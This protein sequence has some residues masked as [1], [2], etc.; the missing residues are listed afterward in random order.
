MGMSGIKIRAVQFDDELLK[1]STEFACALYPIHSNF[2]GD[3]SKRHFL[4]AWVIFDNNTILGRVVAYE[5]PKLHISQNSSVPS[6]TLLLGNYECVDHP[7]SAALLLNTAMEFAKSNGYD[8][9]IGP[10][11]G[12]TWDNYR[13][14]TAITRPFMGETVN[15]DYYPEQWK[16]QG[17]SVLAHYHSS[18]DNQLDTQLTSILNREKALIESGVT[19]RPIDV[20]SF[21]KELKAMHQF[22]HIAF[23]QNAFF[24]PISEEEF[25][26]KYLAIQSI[27]DPYWV[28]IVEDP[29]KNL[30]GYI[31]AYEDRIDPKNETVIL[32]TV[33]RSNHRDYRGLGLILARRLNEK[34]IQRGKKQVIHAY[35]HQE[36]ASSHCSDTMNG[37]LF[38]EYQLFELPLT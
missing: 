9:I 28:E 33:A 4:T 21:E 1:R 31:L 24:T 17:F 8:K 14:K 16:S 26:N 5:N 25:V 23:A 34:A 27:I 30:V 38:A 2:H 3:V 12:S 6:K 32:K 22:N 15:L 29:K 13:F 19:F 18:L 20:G 11:S 37:G 7:E 36:N 35:M 10:M